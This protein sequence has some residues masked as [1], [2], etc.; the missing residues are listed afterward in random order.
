MTFTR[1]ELGHLANTST[2]TAIRILNDM[3]N[4]GIL[5]ISEKIIRILDKNRLD[6]VFRL[7]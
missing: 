6:Q 3:R 5:E 1:K 2:E 7:G 4:E